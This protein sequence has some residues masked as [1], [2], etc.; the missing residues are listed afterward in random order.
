MAPS[1]TVHRFAAG[2]KG[3]VALYQ[4]AT[5]AELVDLYVAPAYRGQ[6]IGRR[7]LTR[8]LK[9]AASQCLSVKLRVT[10]FAAT[11]LMTTDALMSMYARY[12]FVKVAAE[13]MIW[14]PK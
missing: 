8:A 9:F 13:E 14:H 5:H 10:P 6:G 1:I 7:L 11:T 4:Y 12:G 3:E 2:A